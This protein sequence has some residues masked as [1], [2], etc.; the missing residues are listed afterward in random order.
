MF[1]K[2]TSNDDSGYVDCISSI[3]SSLVGV[4]K[5]V[6]ITVVNIDNWFDHKWVGFEGKELGVIAVHW[7]YGF[8]IPA[9]NPSRVVR[10]S[11][12]RLN[13]RDSYAAVDEPKLHRK[14][15]SNSNF[16]RDLFGV[17]DSSLFVWWSGGTATNSQ[18]SLMVYAR[19]QSTKEAWY[20]SF[21][22]NDSWEVLRTY[23]IQRQ[24]VVDM[25]KSSIADA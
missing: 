14:Q 19:T 3:V 18:G 22:L 24:F 5:P 9:F 21:K 4:Y 12:F 17:D 23:R 10:Q 16:K 7:N 2:A 8:N 20:A 11:D 13:D 15:K 6:R 1:V 25:M